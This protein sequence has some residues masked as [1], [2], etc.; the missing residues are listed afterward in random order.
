MRALTSA[1][2]VDSTLSVGAMLHLAFSLHG[3]GA[4]AP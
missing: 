2:S 1:V 3:F 4:S